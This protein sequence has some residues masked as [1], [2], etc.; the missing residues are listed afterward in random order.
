MIVIGSYRRVIAT[1]LL[2][3][4]ILFTLSTL[5]LQHRISSPTS[6]PTAPAALSPSPPL[7]LNP[8]LVPS[9]SR[10]RLV[11][12]SPTL[13]VDDRGRLCAPHELDPA[14]SCCASPDPHRAQPSCL[15]CRPLALL[16]LD[17][18]HSHA[19]SRHGVDPSEDRVAYP[20]LDESRKLCCTSY[21]GCLS[22]CMKPALAPHAR[23]YFAKLQSLDFPPLRHYAVPPD[24]LFL[25]CGILCR[26]NS[27]SVRNENAY[28]HAESPYCFG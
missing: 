10:C 18:A 16:L 15:H 28:L 11:H 21:E 23:F 17:A 2:C 25:L 3:F 4:L 6:T 9:P 26:T 14:S 8:A 7:P 5:W 22:C 19:P 20:K 12:Q 1:I 27:A 24:D 13:L